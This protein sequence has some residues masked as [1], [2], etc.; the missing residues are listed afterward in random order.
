M[1]KKDFSPEF[2]KMV[3]ELKEQGAP[4][5]MINTIELMEAYKNIDGFAQYVSNV[6]FSKTY[7]D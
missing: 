1:K 5:E 7:N 6:S 3:E 2:K 4:D